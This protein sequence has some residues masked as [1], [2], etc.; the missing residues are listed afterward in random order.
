MLSTR[1]LPELNQAIK[2]KALMANFQKWLVNQKVESVSQNSKT[3]LKASSSLTNSGSLSAS[4][5]TMSSINS[6]DSTYIATHNGKLG[7]QL[8][9]LLLEVFQ[10]LHFPA[11]PRTGTSSGRSTTSQQ[12]A[13]KLLKTRL[14]GD[15]QKTIVFTKNL[16]LKLNRE[17]DQNSVQNST[18]KEI[19]A[20][21]LISLREKFNTFMQISVEE[22][23]LT[24]AEIMKLPDSE[25]NSVLSRVM[26]S[27]RSMKKSRAKKQATL[28]DRSELLL[29]LQNAAFCPMNFKILFFLQF[30]IENGPKEN[31]PFADNDLIFYVEISRFK[32]TPF[33]NLIHLC[34]RNW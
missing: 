9:A 27:E 2:I 22:T 28:E 19:E 34:P 4:S 1:K 23:G 17:L 13:T 26:R 30:L 15:P 21:L 32:V 33:F 18:L 29:L 8:L 10:F 20:F 16:S 6:K 25:M 24:A 14:R 3:T 7:P 11:S 5:A 31:R 12:P